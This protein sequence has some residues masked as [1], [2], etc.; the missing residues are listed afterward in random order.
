MHSP[1]CLLRSFLTIALYKCCTCTSYLL[2]SAKLVTLYAIA[3]RILWHPSNESSDVI[4]ITDSH[5]VLWDTEAS[6]TSVRVSTGACTVLLVRN[7]K[8]YLGI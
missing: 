1:R 6:G 5:V 3:L 2:R 4:T 8:V 7:A